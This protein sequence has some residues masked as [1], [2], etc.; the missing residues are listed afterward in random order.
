MIGFSDDSSHLLVW[1]YREDGEYVLV[2]YYDLA[3]R[4]YVDS[5]RVDRAGYTAFGPK[6][7]QLTMVDNR[8]GS[9][10]RYDLR[11]ESMRRR[12]AVY[13]NRV[14]D[15][16]FSPG[17]EWLAAASSRSIHIWDIA[18][19][20]L[21]LT[22]QDEESVD[23]IAFSDDCH[24]VY[25]AQSRGLVRRPLED[26]ETSFLIRSGSAHIF[27]FAPRV[28]QAVVGRRVD[29]WAAVVDLVDGREQ[30]FE[31]H[32]DDLSSLALSDDGALLAVSGEWRDANSI[33]LWD[34]PQ[35]VLLDKLPI[36]VG[37]YAL[38][39]SRDS[40]LLA[41]T[42]WDGV[43]KLWSI[44]P[45][46]LI[47]SVATRAIFTDALEFSPDG[48]WLAYGESDHRPVRL[49]DLDS[50][51]Q[52]AAHAANAT[53]YPNLISFSPASDRVAVGGWGGR[54]LVWDTD[55]A[56]TRTVSSPCGDIDIGPDWDGTV[57]A[58]SLEAAADLEISMTAG[59]PNPVSANTT[60]PFTLPG[61]ATVRLEV[62]NLAGQLVRV[63]ADGPYTAGAHEVLWDGRGEDGR[64]VA[65]GV[66]LI[67]MTADRVQRVGKL[68]I[69]R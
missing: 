12:T 28:R 51:T 40:D 36:H 26:P 31:G 50:G 16:A 13:M 56:G 10:V 46:V 23:G 59:R 57:V 58:G 55:D 2:R 52:V 19:R 7:M 45:T 53:I 35:R 18:S 63:L 14:D 39:F 4:Q 33:W 6:S 49:L 17:G 67:R 48:R 68:L 37:G 8:A 60:V 3:S 42:D 62:Y 64:S 54:V 69:V 32:P 66:Y 20:T 1:S 5:L 41:A 34:V 38:A 29:G 9:I 44:D 22:L 15:I 43:V 30:R 21:L 25:V 24:D 47:D 11:D 27:A 61:S 65:S